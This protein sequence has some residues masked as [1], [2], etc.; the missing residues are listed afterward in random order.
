MENEAKI[1][2]KV[3]A[4]QQMEACHPDKWPIQWSIYRVPSHKY[5]RY[6]VFTSVNMET[7]ALRIVGSCSLGE[8]IQ[9]CKETCCLM[10]FLRQ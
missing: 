7:T 9:C 5:M 2:K 1:G 8:R 4:V 6:E 10:R 3:L